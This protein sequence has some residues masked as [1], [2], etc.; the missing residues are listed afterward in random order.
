MPILEG[1]IFKG[2]TMITTKESVVD[3]ANIV[4]VLGQAKAIHEKNRKEIDYLYSYYRGDQPILYRAKE[5]RPNIN[6]KL[7]INRANEIVSF[8]TGYLC[9][10]PIQYTSEETDENISKQVELLNKMMNSESKDYKDK[11]LVDWFNICGTAYRYVEPDRVRDEDNSP[12]SI[13]TLDPRSTFIIYSGDFRHEPLVAVTYYSDTE[14]EV[15]SAYTKD[16]YFEVRNGA[17]TVI[18]SNRIKEIPI[19]EYPAN[20]ARLGA[21]EVVL[22]LLDALN[23][24]ESNRVDGLEQFVQSFIRFINCDIDEDEYKQFLMDGAIKVY[25]HEGN[26]ASVDI[27]SS[28]LSQTDTQVQVEDIYSAILT[29]CG[30]PSVSTGNTSDSSNNGAVILKNGWQG[31]E[32]RAKDSELMFRNSEMQMLR[33]VLKI[34]RGKSTGINLRVKN[35]GLKF[36]RR[37][38]EAIA[39]KSQVLIS[40]LNTDKIHPRLAFEHCGMFPDPEAAYSMSREHYEEQMEKWNPIE[41]NENDSIYESGQS[42]R[43]DKEETENPNKQT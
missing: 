8:K 37:N 4:A 41:V 24:I 26:Q 12:F 3:E 20:T 7:V 21:F 5:F 2:R 28:T 25:S 22:T 27:V 29:I 23:R 18:D 38:Y 31:A 19:I 35:I 9:G 10:A 30:M 16:N 11:E 1:H 43:T 34:L 36:T 15:Y 39:Q 40:M 32:A 6:N 14:G 42:G 17:V 13:Y 33:I